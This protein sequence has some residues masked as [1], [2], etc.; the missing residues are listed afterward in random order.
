M[1][2]YF[3]ASRFYKDQYET[4]YTMIVSLLKKYDYEVIDNSIEKA[5]LGVKE[6]SIEEKVDHY[7][8]TTDFLDKSDFSI[9]EASFPSTLHIGHEISL[10]IEKGKP[11][12][13]LYSDEPGKAPMLFQG[14]KSDRIIWAAYNK[15]NLAKVVVQ[16]IE[17]ARAISDVRFNFF[18]SPRLLSYLDFVAKKK[19]IPRSVFLRDL[20]DREM[21]KDKEFKSE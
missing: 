3:S 15:T 20:I 19:M 13:V 1:K 5:P 8:K 2:V 7:K 21:K 10:A 11:V 12:V 17:K 4:V 9:F 14:I 16:A 6:M 18:I